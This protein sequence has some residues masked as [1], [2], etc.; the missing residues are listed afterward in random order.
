MENNRHAAK[1]KHIYI[2]IYRPHINEQ[3]TQKQEDATIIYHAIVIDIPA[4]YLS[5]KCH[6]FATPAD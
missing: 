4:M 1:V 5:L 3:L 6:K 2:Y